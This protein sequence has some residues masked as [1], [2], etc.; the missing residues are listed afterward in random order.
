MY[1]AI[2]R[3][4]IHKKILIRKLEGKT[5]YWWEVSSVACS[6][7]WFLGQ[8]NI[9]LYSSFRVKDQFHTCVKQQ[10]ETVVLYILT[11]MFIDGRLKDKLYLTKLI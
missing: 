1:Y 6:Y 7:V 4:E 8:N 2:E 3:R 10:V 9:N 5:R 11:F